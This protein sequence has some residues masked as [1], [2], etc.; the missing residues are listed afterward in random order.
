M[1][2]YIC[3]DDALMATAVCLEDVATV[4]FN[5]KKSEIEVVYRSGHSHV[6][7]FDNLDGATKFFSM[8]CQHHSM[9]WPPK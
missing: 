5:K 9:A 6:I 8:F 4:K 2:G 7:S 1:D 3:V